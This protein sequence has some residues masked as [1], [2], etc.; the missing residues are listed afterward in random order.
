VARQP[1]WVGVLWPGSPSGWVFWGSA[2]PVGV[3][4]VAAQSQWLCVLWPAV[5][6]GVAINPRGSNDRI[7]TVGVMA[8][9]EVCGG[10]VISG[11]DDSL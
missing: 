11:R 4:A 2:V 1:Q 10:T 6:V 9:D 8:V 3:C 7:V 5:R